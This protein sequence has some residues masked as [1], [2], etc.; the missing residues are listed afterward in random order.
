[1]WGRVESGCTLLVRLV[2]LALQGLQQEKQGRRLVF[3]F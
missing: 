3:L 1:M 2:C